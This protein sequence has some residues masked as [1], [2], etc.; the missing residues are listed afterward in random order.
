ME[1]VLGSVV[2]GSVEVD[3][4]FVPFEGGVKSELIVVPGV[5]DVY[6]VVA[7]EQVGPGHVEDVGSGLLLAR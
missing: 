5:D 3:L 7:A 1:F 4:S 2:V 6:E